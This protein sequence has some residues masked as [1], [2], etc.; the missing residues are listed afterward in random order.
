MH[1]TLGHLLQAIGASAIIAAIGLTAD[2][3]AN[4]IALAVGAGLVVYG[5]ILRMM[6]DDH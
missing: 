2:A 3:D 5:A 6:S 1:D 4:G